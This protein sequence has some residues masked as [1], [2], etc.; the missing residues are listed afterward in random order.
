MKKALIVF[1]G[2]GTTQKYSEEISQF[3]SNRGLQTEIIPASSFKPEELSNA[4]YLLLSGWKNGH[5]FSSAKPDNEWIRFIKNLPKLTG[6]KT[7]LFNTNKLFAKGVLRKMKKHLKNKI[8]DIE[9][10]FTSRNGT[11]TVHDKITLNEFIR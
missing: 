5:L 4:D 11:L 2:N 6:M 10:V 9:F 1:H 8:E 3:L 7:A